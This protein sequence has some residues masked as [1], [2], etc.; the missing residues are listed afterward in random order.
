MVEYAKKNNIDVKKTQLKNLKNNEIFSEDIIKE[1]FKM[2]DKQINLITD[3]TLSKNFIVYIDNTKKI[4]IEKNSKDYEKYKSQ[5]KLNL[6]RDIYNVYDKSVN[7][8]YKID[9]NNKALERIKNSF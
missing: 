9:V 8:K 3:S 5:A 1:I 4:S 6:A 2:N 7:N